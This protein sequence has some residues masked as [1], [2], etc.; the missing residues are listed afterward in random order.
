M[1]LPNSHIVVE[2]NLDEIPSTSGGDS[3]VLRLLTLKV[4]PFH[5]IFNLNG[6]LIATRFDKGGYGNV[7]FRTII[8][9]PRLKEFLKK[10]LVQFDT[11][12]W[13]LA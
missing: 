10:C 2:V 3:L 6:V 7:A 5:V 13:S 4:S 8:L 11:Y 1:E 9:H 12:I